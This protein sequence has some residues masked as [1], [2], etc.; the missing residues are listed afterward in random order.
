MSEHLRDYFQP[1]VFNLHVARITF[2]A[3]FKCYYTTT[4]VMPVS[5]IHVTALPSVKNYKT[6]EHDF[7][8][9]CYERPPVLRDRFCWAEGV[10][11]QDRFYCNCDQL[12]HDHCNDSVHSECLVPRTKATLPVL[13]FSSTNVKGQH[14]LCHLSIQWSTLNSHYLSL[15]P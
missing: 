14:P 6:T 9:I 15:S 2:H 8:T 11:A 13:V 7:C 4:S 10:V 3:L 5:L 1:A 12:C